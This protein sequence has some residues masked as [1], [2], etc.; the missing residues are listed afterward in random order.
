MET[1]AQKTTII[2][3][4][5]ALTTEDLLAQRDTIWRE[6]HYIDAELSR[7]SMKPLT[8]EQ[9]AKS[10]E[11]CRSIGRKVKDEHKC[12]NCGEAGAH[13]VPPSMGE[14]GFYFCKKMEGA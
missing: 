13:F 14:E 6:F 8:E 9:R 12:L 3:C 10:L 5:S 2:T 4:L 11:V 1:K 7:R